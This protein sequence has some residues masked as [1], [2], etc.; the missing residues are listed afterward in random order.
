M[1]KQLQNSIPSIV[2]K[3]NQLTTIAKKLTTRYQVLEEIA[4][5]SGKNSKELKAALDDASKEM[6]ELGQELGKAG[7]KLGKE[8]S[9]TGTK[10]STLST[11]IVGRNSKKAAKLGE[12]LAK[13]VSVRLKSNLQIDSDY[14]K[15]YMTQ[16]AKSLN[17]EI[18]SDQALKHMINLLELDKSI[19]KEGLTNFAKEVGPDIA[20]FHIGLGVTLG[21]AK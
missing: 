6:A 5:N 4:E 11:D 1:A 17:T 13:K 8:L 15:Q 21:T 2:A 19:T 20:A 16:T 7:Q 12:A 14:L 10:V 18:D 9:E 3:N